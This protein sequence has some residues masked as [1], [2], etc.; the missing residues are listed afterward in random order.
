VAIAMNEA[1]K[2]RKGRKTRKP[3][4]GSKVSAVARTK[5]GGKAVSA[6]ARKR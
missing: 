6:V 2:A 3:T 5:A 4:H 1:G